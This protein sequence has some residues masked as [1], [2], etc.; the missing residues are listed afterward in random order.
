LNKNTHRYTSVKTHFV[1]GDLLTLT[2]DRLTSKW[3]RKLSS[4]YTQRSSINNCGSH[5][6]AKGTVAPSIRNDC[7][8]DRLRQ[9][10]PHV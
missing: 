5:C 6:R 1:S 8:G 4:V 7:R 10:L 3:H 9:R 2:F